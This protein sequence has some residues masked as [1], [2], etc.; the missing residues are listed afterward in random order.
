M[1]KALLAVAVGVLALAAIP[2]ALAEPRPDP[3]PPAPMTGETFVGDE[4]NVAPSSCQGNTITF[5]INGAVAVGPYPGTV[6]ESGTIKLG[7]PVPGTPNLFVVDEFHATF[8]VTQE[9]PVNDFVVEI[10][11]V[12]TG[13]KDFVRQPTDTGFAFA[14]C[15]THPTGNHLGSGLRIGV[16]DSTVQA[17]YEATIRTD[18]GLFHDEGTTTV[19]FRECRRGFV[20]APPS[21]CADPSGGTRLPTMFEETFASTLGQT[22][23]IVTPPGNSPVFQPGRGCGDENHEHE[24]EASCG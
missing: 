19:Q 2:L 10:V 20:F 9:R 8:K 24:R 13:T 5:N 12:V 23:P 22:I 4:N 1:R 3:A 15:E 16:A 11:E 21:Q 18:E 6:L 14:F 17:R 7:A